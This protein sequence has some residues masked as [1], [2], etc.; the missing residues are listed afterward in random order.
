MEWRTLVQGHYPGAMYY[1]EVAERYVD[2]LE[3]QVGGDRESTL[4][5]KSR[6]SDDANAAW[7]VFTNV[8]KGPFQLGGLSG[9]P[10]AG[11]TGMTAY[12]HHIPND[13]TA[14]IF[15][16]PHIGINAQGTI[17]KMRR[18]GQSNDS[19]CCGALLLA[20]SRMQNEDPDDPYL[21]LASDDDYQ[22]TMIEHAVIP[23]KQRILFSSDPTK[24][25]TEVMYGVIRRQIRRLVEITR[26]E[27]RCSR[28]VLLGGIFINTDHGIEDFFDARDFETITAGSA[29]EESRWTTLEKRVKSQG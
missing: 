26:A 7:P 3:K 29:A 11:K 21:P 24:E 12:A 25:I 8:F 1:H 20:L 4:I 5:A 18:P 16:G 14:L 13:G 23:F 10:F 19:S 15:Y 27:F 22:Q 2:L 28:I 9:L 17:G 6:C